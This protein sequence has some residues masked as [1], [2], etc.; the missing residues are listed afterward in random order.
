MSSKKSLAT[1]SLS[2]S[3]VTLLAS[4]PVLA[5]DTDFETKTLEKGYNTEKSN[6]D[7][8]KTTDAKCGA[9]KCGTDKCGSGACAGAQ[10]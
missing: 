3:L 4:I 5:D 8:K 7:D 10:S 9:G 2:A 6:S 1:L